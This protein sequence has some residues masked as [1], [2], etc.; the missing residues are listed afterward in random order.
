[1]EPGAR[2]LYSARRVVP[3]VS[4][5]LDGQSKSFVMPGWIELLRLC[6]FPVH[7]VL[8]AAPGFSRPFYIEDGIFFADKIVIIDEEFF[9][10][11]DK[12]L[13][14]VIDVFDMSIAVILVLHGND[15]VVALLLLFLTLRSL[16]D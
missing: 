3:G 2:F 15:A 5:Y 9:K 7:T 10:F 16:N 12:G 4:F 11:P 13:S 14:Q 1:M 8:Y 6:L